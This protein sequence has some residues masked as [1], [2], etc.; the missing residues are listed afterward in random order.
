[1]SMINKYNSSISLYSEE[2]NY[3]RNQILLLINSYKERFINLKKKEQKY[4][5]NKFELPKL[6][7][8]KSFQQELDIK[9]I[10][11]GNSGNKIIKKNNNIKKQVNTFSSYDKRKNFIN[12]LKIIRNNNKSKLN[13]IESQKII[14]NDKINF[15]NYNNNK[16]NDRKNIREFGKSFLIDNN[17][18]S[19]KYTL[20]KKKLWYQNKYKYKNGDIYN[21]IKNNNNNCYNPITINKYENIKEE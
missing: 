3:K 15:N 1:M 8:N 10:S 2:E 21:L 9:D 11:L 14:F 18:L 19:G 20:W 17:K 4:A 5:F 7:K 6:V 16:C 12:N 13:I